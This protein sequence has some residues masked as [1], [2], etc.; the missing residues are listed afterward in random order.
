MKPQLN[1]TFKLLTVASLASLGGAGCASHEPAE[2]AYVPPSSYLSATSN[3][4]HARVYADTTEVD[5]TPGIV[6]YDNAPVVRTS[7]PLV[8]VVR[9]AIEEDPMLN[10]ACKNVDIAVRGSHLVLRGGVPTNHDRHFVESRLRH[11]PGVTVVENHLQSDG[12]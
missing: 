10:E 11:L 6:A 2:T 3:R 5:T 12:R 1:L 4:D 7:V 8:D 9:Q